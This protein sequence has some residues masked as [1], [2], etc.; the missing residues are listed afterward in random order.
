V[1]QLFFDGASRMDP[2]E[3]IVAGGGVVLVSSQNYM[4]PRALLEIEKSRGLK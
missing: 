2:R 3:N 4:I 1:W